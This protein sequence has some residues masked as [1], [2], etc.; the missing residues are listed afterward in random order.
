[1]STGRVVPIYDLRAETAE[2]M[3]Q[4]Y[5]AVRTG[6]GDDEAIHVLADLTASTIEDI[7]YQGCP[8]GISGREAVAVVNRPLRPS[9][10]RLS[11][12]QPS[13]VHH[14]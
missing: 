9:A 7:E 1:M 6:F 2:A 11:T 10:C 12:A 4:L 5:L 8:A 3:R 14:G 13:E